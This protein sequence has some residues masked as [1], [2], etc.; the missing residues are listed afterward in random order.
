MIDKLK[1]EQNGQ[2]FAGDILVFYGQFGFLFKSQG[3][4]GGHFRVYSTPDN[5]LP[6]D[7]EHFQFKIS[8]HWFK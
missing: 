8:Q 2:I 6:N 5:D 7:F 4:C 3:H 1:P